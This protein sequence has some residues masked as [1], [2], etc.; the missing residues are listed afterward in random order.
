MNSVAQRVLPYVLLLLSLR[1]LLPW[2]ANITPPGVTAKAE[3]AA[4]VLDVRTPEKCAHACDGLNCPDGWETARDPAD[5]C[6]CIC[7]RSKPG[8]RTAW[9][10]MRAKGR[11]REL[12]AQDAALVQKE[13]GGAAAVD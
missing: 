1:Y 2:L 13:R 3:R 9:D 12:K 10:E 7:A 6:K 11:E 8:E 5:D 4:D